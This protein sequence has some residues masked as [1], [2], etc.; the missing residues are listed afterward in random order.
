[1]GSIELTQGATNGNLTDF[2]ARIE[3]PFAFIDSITTDEEP[4][5]TV[6]W[7]ADGQVI[8]T[9]LFSVDIGLGGTPGDFDNDGDVDGDDFL[10]WQ[11]GFGISSGALREDGDANG[12]GAVNQEDYD[13]WDSN[14]G[15]GEVAG[16]VVSTT[17]PEPACLLLLAVLLLGLPVVRA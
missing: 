13:L 14:F 6:T 17:V 5:I 12:D 15:T 1:M 16:A 10:A 3:M 7:D 2:T 8:S 4:E 9:G 11:E